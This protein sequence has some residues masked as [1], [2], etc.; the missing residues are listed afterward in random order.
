M[1]TST[2]SVISMIA[3][4]MTCPTCGMYK[5]SG[6][7]SCCAPGGAWY[8]NCGFARNRKVAYVW[9]EGVEACKC[10]SNVSSMQW[11][12]V[13]RF[14]LYFLSMLACK[15]QQAPGRASV[16]YAANAAYS[17]NL[18]NEV[19]AVAVVLGLETVDAM[20]IQS[21]VTRGTRA[22]KLAK[23]GRTSRE[24]AANSQTLLNS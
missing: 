10:K 18:A 7:V 9:S 1:H 15:H 24:P 23:R 2:S 8:K 13:F 19:V 12:F 6:T 5:R 21:F 16:P 17:R 4:K 22:S 11:L 20:V 14:S 3:N